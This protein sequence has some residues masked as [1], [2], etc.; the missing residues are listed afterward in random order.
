MVISSFLC[1]FAENQFVVTCCLIMIIPEKE[2]R[3]SMVQEKEELV[4]PHTPAS[5]VIW[6]TSAVQAAVSEIEFVSPV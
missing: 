1:Y 6:S 5:I 4:S 2:K 3:R